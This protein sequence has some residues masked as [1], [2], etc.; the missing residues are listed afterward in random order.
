[1]VFV[2]VDISLCNVHENGDIQCGECGEEPVEVVEVRAVDVVGEPALSSSP[3]RRPVD[4]RHERAA[5]VAPDALRA[6][7]HGE[8]D[9]AE[10]VGH[11]VVE[12]LLEPDD[13][14]HLR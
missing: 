10:V 4:R 3:R 9:A 7:R 13:A 1:L 6:Q 11:L 5:G 8:P 12:E 2:P 14:E